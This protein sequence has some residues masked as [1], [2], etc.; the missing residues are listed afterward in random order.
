MYSPWPAGLV[1][2]KQSVIDYLIEDN[3]VLKE[4]LEGQRLRITDQQRIRLAVKA[5]MLGRRALDELE[6]LVTPD[7]LLIRFIAADGL[8]V[9][10]ISTIVK[11]LESA[12]SISCTQL[13]QS[14]GMVYRR[15]NAV[16]PALG[17]INPWWLR[18]GKHCDN[19]KR[20]IESV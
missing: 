6:T 2:H 10:S 12:R 13:G 16:Q 9:C 7:T 8:A 5:K 11:R 4:Q 15:L 18:F 14:D 20:V 3:H 17:K 1:G 19:R